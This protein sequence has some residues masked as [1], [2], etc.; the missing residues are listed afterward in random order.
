MKGA[1]AVVASCMV[2]VLLLAFG[3]VSTSATA[4]DGCLPAGI[5]VTGA[6]PENLHLDAEQ[7]A[8]ART[9][10]TAV[11]DRRMPSRAAVIAVATALQESSLRNLPHGDADSLGLF[12]QRPSSG[13]GTPT[14]L[15]DP[16]YAT[17]KFLSRLDEL[18]GWQIL[19][20]HEAAQAVQ[21]SAYPDAYAE[22]ERDAGAIVAGLLGR[23]APGTANPGDVSDLPGLAVYGDDLLAG[24]GLPRT[25]QGGAV[26]LDIEP[27]RTLTQTVADLRR[28]ESLPGTLLVSASPA[29]TKRTALRR[30]AA[31]ARILNLIPFDR[32]DRVLLDREVGAL[33][34]KVGPARTVYWLTHPGAAALNDVLRARAAQ[35]RGL[36]VLDV[37]A[38]RGR[39]VVG[40]ANAWTPQDQAAV[41]RLVAQELGLAEIADPTA[42]AEPRCDDGLGGYSSVP[43]ADC[44]FVLPRSNPRSCQDA[45][46]WALAQVDGP[47]IWFHRCLNFV[48]RAYGYSVSGVDN[49]ALFWSRALGVRAGDLN[50]PAGALAFWD[51]G[52]P[53]GHVAL[54]LGGG[55]VISNDI[56]GRG[57]LTVVPL[58]ELTRRWSAQ[59]LGWAPPFFPQGS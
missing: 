6:P 27:A 25:Y 13:W 3:A 5:A 31:P 41:A 51:T 54:S 26:T 9:I 17:D 21:R 58:A 56:G 7:V 35:H 59:Y 4:A 45:M 34:R 36:I 19:P 20:L 2:L 16:A 47:P 18:Q 39:G 43:V 55:L 57:T 48:A 12:Q 44:A 10:V 42:S 8:N 49:A 52:Q 29:P 14:Q 46:R 23:P 30:L 22:R 50:P 11:V 53:E 28:Q 38:P 33:L 37:L 15:L 32:R 24:L 40:G 1:V